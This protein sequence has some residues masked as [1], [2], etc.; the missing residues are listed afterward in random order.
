MKRVFNLSMFGL[1]WAHRPSQ[2]VPDYRY[3][4][5]RYAFILSIEILGYLYDDPLQKVGRV[6]LGCHQYSTHR[7][8]KKANEDIRMAIIY[9]SSLQSCQVC[10]GA[11]YY[12]I[13]HD[14]ALLS[15]S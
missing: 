5:G 15:R 2:P 6:T 11:Y 7:C 3:R 14:L 1:L 8:L 10:I 4:N 9:Y 12:T 13:T